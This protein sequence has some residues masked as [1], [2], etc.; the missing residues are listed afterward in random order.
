METTDRY[1]LQSFSEFSIDEVINNNNLHNKDKIEN[2]IKANLRTEANEDIRIQTFS[3]R[4]R[5]ITENS[6]SEEFSE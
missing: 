2:K 1:A 4:K 3:R 5:A 6:A